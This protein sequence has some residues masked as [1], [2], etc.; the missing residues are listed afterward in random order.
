MLEAKETIHKERTE[1][2]REVKERRA[3]LQ[4][5]ERRLQQKEESLDKKT[6]S[7]E[8]KNE[9]LNKKI[10][11]ADAL[12][13]EIKLIKHSELEM[14]EKI[15]GYSQEEAKD[16][17]LKEIEAEVV[18]DKAMKIKELEARYKEEADQKAREYITLAIQRC[19]ADHVAEATVSVVPLPNDEM[20]GRV[21]GRE[22]RN[23]RTDR[24]DRGKSA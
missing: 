2:E 7:I 1:Y 20:K 15:S 10:S 13:E 24:R 14:L 18:H 22:G 12:R 9:T 6:D 16:Y 5:Q 4:K 11:E 3:E 19:A 23:I 21:I 17:L 8:K